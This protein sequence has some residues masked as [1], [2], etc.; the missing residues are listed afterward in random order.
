MPVTSTL[1]L[2]DLALV[3][4]EAMAGSNMAARMPMMAMTT[5]SSMSVK[6]LRRWTVVRVFMGSLALLKREFSG[7]RCLG[8]EGREATSWIPSSCR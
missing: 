6:A 4:A 8:N 7:R 1:A 2:A 3:V 5:R